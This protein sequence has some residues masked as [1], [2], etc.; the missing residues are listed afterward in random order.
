VTPISGN[1]PWNWS[2][3][4]VNGGMTVSCTAPLQP[5]APIVGVCGSATGV[6]TL[7]TPQSGLCAAGI[8]SA[9]TGRGPWTWSCSG[10]NGGGAVACVAPLAES[11]GTG[12]LPSFVTPSASEAPTP[13]AAPQ[14][15]VQNRGLVTPQLPSGPLPP[16]RNGGSM[17]PMPKAK[18]FA[19]LP[20]PTEV[21]PPLPSTVIE[22]ES[23]APAEPPDLPLD[24]KPLTPPPI[25][26]TIQPTPALKPPAIDDQGAVIPGNHFVLQPELSS[27]SFDTGSENISPDALSTLDKLASTLQ[28]NGNVRVTLTAYAAT[29]SHTTPRDARRLSLA[30]ALAIRDY[31][32]SKG[33]ASSRIDVRALGA[34]VP[35]GDADRVDIK[36]N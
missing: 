15:Q 31:L 30:R 4:G 19:P 6:P 22:Q 9:V 26:D 7:T 35:S 29:G 36:A 25:R 12:S 28:G 18:P 24:T 23:Q 20:Q 1:G 14:S 8:S 5:P 13:L 34:N 2:C 16:I 21:P 17:P 32:T 33:V 27:V 10:T 3:I 11:G